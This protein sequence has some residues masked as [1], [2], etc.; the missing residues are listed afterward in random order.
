MKQKTKY[1]IF[2]SICL[3]AILLAIVS[4]L[5]AKIYSPQNT[6][7]LF[8][9]IT[10]LLSVAAIIFSIENCLAIFLFLSSF[11][12]VYDSFWLKKALTIFI[13]V[14]LIKYL[15]E[16]IL[17]KKRFEFIPFVLSL[18]FCGYCL[19]NFNYD[20][21]GKAFGYMLLIGCL[22]LVF[23]YIDNINKKKMIWFYVVGIFCSVF[24]AVIIDKLPFE[25]SQI[26]IKETVRFSA[27]AKHANTLQMITGIAIACMLGLYLT[28]K[29]NI[30]KFAVVLFFLIGI[31]LLTKSKGFLVTLCVLLIIFLI[32]QFFKNKKVF[33]FSLVII[34]LMGVLFFNK[35]EAIV[36]RFFLN[37]HVDFWDKIFT[38]RYSIWKNYLNTCTSSFKVAMLG[39]GGSALALK[40]EAHN[41][42]LELWFRFG[43]IGIGLLIG[44][45]VTYIVRINKSVVSKKSFAR[46]LPLI[47]FIF[48]GFEESML[49][50]LNIVLV[51]C[52][53]FMKKDEQQ[54][55]KEGNMKSKLKFVKGKDVLSFFALMLVFI[56]AMIAKIFIRDFWLV[57]E[58][59][60]EAR[61]NGYWLFKYIRENHPKQK[62]AYA[63]NKKSV[64]YQ[65]VKNLG[66][67]IS[68]GSLSHWF[69]YLVAD[70]NISSQKNGKPNAAVCY[71]FEVVLKMR[72][73]NRYFLQHG[74]IKDILDFLLF[75]NTNMYRFSVSTR[76]EY[77]FVCKNFGYP[78]GHICLTGLCRFDGLNDAKTDPNQILVMPTWRQWISKGVET[79]EIEGSDVFTETNFFKT[80]HGFLN[81]EKVDKLLKTYNK[82]IVFYPHRNMQKFI[83][84]FTTKSDNIVIANSQD[85]DVQA[86]LKQSAMLIT[87]F[88]S[89]YF[90]F[91]YM[92]K[93]I[94][95]YQFDEEQF[96][97]H[98]YSEGYFDYHN[99]ELGEW[100][101]DLD[102]L[103]VLMEKNLKNNLQKENPNALDGYFAYRDNKNCERN[104]LMIKGI[105]K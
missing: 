19:I 29:I 31:G 22:Y 68:F 56:P 33:L 47:I 62:V 80:W 79:K 45:F 89:V 61:D 35:I 28:N 7:A 82:K 93:P 21:C 65:K 64:D 91:A 99:N 11:S 104:Y 34:T 105:K 63:I 37:Y 54:F 23:V 95:F 59:K 73:K 16:I 92:N 8:S 6:I 30:S 13:G 78:D 25:Q 41:L 3:P 50:A 42:F 40:Y 67:I 9:S 71:F 97:K 24:C 10:V 58:D 27:L 83:T 66:K 74:I 4:L 77:D 90:D 38:G 81:S 98:Q 43:F 53:I 57:C 51:L 86:L 36:N 88:S 20:N 69:W 55:K 96:R 102:E 26:V 1:K 12:G 39:Y 84:E 15:I 44:L 76:D 85:Y 70:K 32:A 52:F 60:N 46:F 87:D 75:K 101:G 17:K 72:K 2:E 100:C 94:I 14:Y 18:L 5:I 103:V 48:I 49:P